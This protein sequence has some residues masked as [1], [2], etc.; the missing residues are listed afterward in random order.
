[1]SELSKSIFVVHTFSLK[2]GIR[3]KTPKNLLNLTVKKDTE[4]S[5]RFNHSQNFQINELNKERYN[6][7]TIL[8]VQKE[9]FAQR[10]FTQK[11][12]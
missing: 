2:E 1:V 7:K 8:P 11:D 3:K 9:K 5:T 4:Y 6:S 10:S 12:L